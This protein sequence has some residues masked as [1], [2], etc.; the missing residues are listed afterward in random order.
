MNFFHPNSLKPFV[1]CV[2][3]CLMLIVGAACS[4]D[5][6]YP[7]KYKPGDIVCMKLDGAKA[8][9]LNVYLNHAGMDIRVGSALTGGGLISEATVKP[10]ARIF[11]TEFEVEDCK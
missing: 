1:T 5:D 11:V 7:H 9:V 8:M 2:A 10:Y 3:I 4:G 6:P